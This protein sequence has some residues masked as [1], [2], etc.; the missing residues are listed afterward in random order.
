MTTIAEAV[1]SLRPETEWTMVGDKIAGITW[2]T[3]NVEPLTEPEVTK[4]M[5]RLKTVALTTEANRVAALQAARDFALS[6]GFTPAMLAVM[7]PQLTEA[8]SE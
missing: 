1:S 6:L 4:E 8:P 2:H 3:P 5:K 7:Y